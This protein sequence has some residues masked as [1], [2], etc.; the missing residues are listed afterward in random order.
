MNKLPASLTINL[1]RVRKNFVI[2]SDSVGP[3]CD[4]APVV[5][6]DAYGLGM[7][8]IAAVLHEE[9]AKRFFVASP[10]EGVALRG[11]L[12][13]PEIAILNGFYKG[14]EED[15]RAYDL[16]PVLNSLEEI[17]RYRDALPGGRGYLHFD[18]GM[19]RL[20]LG[21]DE[22]EILLE[23]MGALDGLDVACVMSHFACA[24]EAD[25]PMNRAQYEK[26]AKIAQRFPDARKSLANS[27]G[28]F[29]SSDY[30]FDMIRPGR[31]LYGLNPTPEKENPMRDVIGLNVKILQVREAQK[32]E[33]VGYNATYRFDKKT[34]LA[35]VALGYADGFFVTLSG[36]GQLFWRGIALPVVGR[37]S[38]DLVSVD[39]SAVPEADMPVVGDELEVIGPN[40]SVDALADSAGTIGYEVLT[41]LGARYERVYQGQVTD[42]TLFS[43][44]SMFS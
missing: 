22:T 28:V 42:N 15:Y 24:D 7:K 23:D 26:F 10:A 37:V 20:G 25:H 16:L 8:E 35:S 27:S 36:K 17:V 44:S 30:H 6:A 18:T 12:K 39:L 2:F 3:D 29:R 9:G 1:E 19:N 38:M 41:A 4:V 11:A 34:K 13:E 21:A 32:D 43:A 40:Q 14:Y 33:T 5:K 31:G